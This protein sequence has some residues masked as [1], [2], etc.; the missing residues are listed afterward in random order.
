MKD[1]DGNYVFEKNPDGTDKDFTLSYAPDQ[2]SPKGRIPKIRRTRF[3]STRTP[4]L[5]FRR[6]GSVTS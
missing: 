2:D 3:S 1:K 6:T 4:F 5:L